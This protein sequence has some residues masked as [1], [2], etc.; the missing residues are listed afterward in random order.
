ML[1]LTFFRPNENSA[2]LDAELE[3]FPKFLLH[4]NKQRI[5]KIHQYLIRMRKLRKTV[6]PK[7]VTVQKKFDRREEKR[8]KKALK[9][10]QLSKTIE[11]ELLSR[12][13]KG[14]YNGIYNFPSR[15]YANALENVEL[16]EEAEEER[17]VAYERDPDSFVNAGE[18]VDDDSSSGEDDDDDDDDQE[19]NL[20]RSFVE[21]DFY[22]SDAS[23]SADDMEDLRFTS[24]KKKSS[25]KKRKPYVEIEYEDEGEIETIRR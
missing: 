20:K 7:L 22:D 8:E 21:G 1:F 9:A 16:Q 6:Q 2:V 17:D 12:L 3:Y 4:K 15:E 18:F 23:Q 25:R 5:T 19:G 10:A 13:S 24:S 14:V 11:N